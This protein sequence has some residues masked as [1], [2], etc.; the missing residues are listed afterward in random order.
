MSITRATKNPI[1][2]RSKERNGSKVLKL[3]FN[4]AP[5]NGVGIA[6]FATYK[7]RTPTGVRQE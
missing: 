1:R 3:K 2:L 6:F 4:S 5:S 7:H